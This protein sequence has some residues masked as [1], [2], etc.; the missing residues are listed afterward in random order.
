MG[1]DNRFDWCRE[2]VRGPR[3]TFTRW[4]FEAGVLLDIFQLR[5]RAVESEVTAKRAAI[6]TH[7]ATETEPAIGYIAVFIGDAPPSAY[8]V[9]L[10]KAG[11][12]IGFVL[13]VAFDQAAP[14]Y[15]GVGR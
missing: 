9:E 3:H 14:P 1:T 12:P 13:P 10:A 15:A 4:Y 5:S 2:W 8:F 6:A 7:N 11:E